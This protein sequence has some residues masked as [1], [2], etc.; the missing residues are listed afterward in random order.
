MIDNGPLFNPSPK[1]QQI[2]LIAGHSCWVIDNVLLAPERML[3]WAQ[4]Q[5]YAPL[6]GIPYPGVCADLPAAVTAG[7]SAFID[8]HLRARL[9]ADR[10]VDAAARVS[11]V[12]TPPAQLAP[13]QWI[14]HR[15]RISDSRSIMLAAS[16]LYLFHDASLGGTSFYKPRLPDEQMAQLII[17]SMRLDAPTFTQRYGIEPGYM[18][19]TNRYFEQIASVPAAWNRLIVYN[20]GLF[21]SGDIFH[22]ERLSTD[23]AKG[24]L[25]LNGFF[26]CEW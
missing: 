16:V 14:C 15:D 23:P 2:P 17:D 7:L 10:I 6:R 12:T 4:G 19:G 8:T 24:R 22:P 20:G 1:I 11:L 3:A 9:G 21:H 18:V 5:S 26:T 25:S 13:C